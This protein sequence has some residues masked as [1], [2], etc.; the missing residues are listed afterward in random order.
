MG[1]VAAEPAYAEG[2]QYQLYLVW[3]TKMPAKGQRFEIPEV[4]LLP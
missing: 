1:H 2:Q 4:Q 3:F